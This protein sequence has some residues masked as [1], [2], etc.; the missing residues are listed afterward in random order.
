[1]IAAT[2]ECF[3][4]CGLTPPTNQP[5]KQQQTRI[6]G[7]NALPTGTQPTP[8][9]PAPP[10]TAPTGPKIIEV[11]VGRDNK[12]TFEPDDIAANAGDIIRFTFFAKN[13]T[14][15]QSAFT[16]PCTKLASG[17]GF[18]SGLCVISLGCSE[19]AI[20]TWIVSQ[21]SLRTSFRYSICGS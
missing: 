5:T 20:E 14:V 15:T 9:A 2:K 11:A 12:L 6:P 8:A 21:L 4:R 3:T 7:K 1:M 16:D 10:T 19:I 13:H 17:K 18:N